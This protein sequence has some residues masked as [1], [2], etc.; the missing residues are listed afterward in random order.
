MDIK[1][2]SFKICGLRSISP[3]QAINGLNHL[4]IGIPFK[5]EYNMIM[6]WIKKFSFSSAEKELDL[7][8]NTL[9][10]SEVVPSGKI[11]TLSPEDKKLR[12]LFF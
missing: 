6:G 5:S 4:F 9:L 12:I 3:Y 7:K 10:P 8:F 11:K 1:L 2:T